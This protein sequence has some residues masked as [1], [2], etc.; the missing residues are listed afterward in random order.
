M[1]K[2]IRGRRKLGMVDGRVKLIWRWVDEFGCTPRLFRCIPAQREAAEWRRRWPGSPETNQ[3]LGMRKKQKK[4]FF[5]SRNSRSHRRRI[6]STL[7]RHRT[8]QSRRIPMHWHHRLHFLQHWCRWMFARHSCKFRRDSPLNSVRG[9][10]LSCRL[11]LL[12]RCCKRWQAKGA[13]EGQFVS[14]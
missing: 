1:D 3:K 13:P 5:D 2:E 6:G 4:F 10:S 8:T 14:T 12:T 11:V 7:G 9:Q